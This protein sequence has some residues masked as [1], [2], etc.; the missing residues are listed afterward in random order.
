VLRGA[1]ATVI[2]V[3]QPDRQYNRHQTLN[4]YTHNINS[5]DF[6]LYDSYKRMMDRFCHFSLD[7]DS[8]TLT[9]V[10]FV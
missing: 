6:T 5:T 10:V 7:S 1:T 4:R 8:Y 2:T 3:R 9:D